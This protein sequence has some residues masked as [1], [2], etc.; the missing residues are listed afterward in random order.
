[1]VVPGAVGTETEQKGN[2]DREIR[3]K[4]QRKG[5]RQRNLLTFPK[6]RK[7]AKRLYRLEQTDWSTA[8]YCSL[9]RPLE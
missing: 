8:R 4:T 2:K 6:G 1:M 7:G 3:D 5:K 9:Y